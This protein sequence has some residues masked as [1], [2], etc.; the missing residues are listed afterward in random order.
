MR[1]LSYSY[2]VYSYIPTSLYFHLQKGASPLYSACFSRFN[3]QEQRLEIAK[4]LL[5]RG[6]D[7]N[8]IL[9]VCAVCCVFAV[10]CDVSN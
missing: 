1:I 9:T 4:L 8:Q 3:S 10:I 2:Y 7:P 5:E 6:F